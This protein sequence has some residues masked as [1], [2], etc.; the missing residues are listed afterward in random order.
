VRTDFAHLR[1]RAPVGRRTV[2]EAVLRSAGGR[3]APCKSGRP[4]VA[5]MWVHSTPGACPRGRQTAPLLGSLAGVEAPGRPDHRS[6]RC[7]GHRVVRQPGGDESH[8]AGSRQLAARGAGA[9][10]RAAA[11][12]TCSDGLGG[13]HVHEHARPDTPCAPHTPSLGAQPLSGGRR[14]PPH[15][16][17]HWCSAAVVCT[18]RRGGGTCLSGGLEAAP[19]ERSYRSPWATFPH[20]GGVLQTLT[21][22]NSWANPTSDRSL[23]ARH[24]AC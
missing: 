9:R 13:A 10:S 6:R 4:Q 8:Q 19:R 22:A 17:E 2:S 12:A 23:A 11:H 7:P 16:L 15:P 24:P 5:C 3:T 20:N 14:P 1:H 21:Y 18:G